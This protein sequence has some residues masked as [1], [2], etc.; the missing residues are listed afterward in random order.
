[1]LTVTVTYD[2]GNAPSFTGQISQ[3]AQI[4]NGAAACERR[5]GSLVAASSARRARRG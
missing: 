5:P 4:W 3:A 1:M 2:T